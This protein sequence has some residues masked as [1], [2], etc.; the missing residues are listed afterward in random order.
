MNPRGF[1]LGLIVGTISS[2]LLGQWMLFAASKEMDPPNGIP[3]ETVA[4]YVHSVIQA[5]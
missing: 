2:C 4:D 3:A 1:W 5:D